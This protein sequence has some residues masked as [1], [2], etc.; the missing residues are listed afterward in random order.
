MS[1][2]RLLA[3]TH[4]TKVVTPETIARCKQN[5]KVNELLEATK[6]AAIIHSKELSM[7]Q[8]LAKIEKRE[9]KLAHK[10]GMTYDEW[11]GMS[12]RFYTI[13]AD[14][15]SVTSIARSPDTPPQVWYTNDE[16]EARVK[17]LR[18]IGYKRYDHFVKGHDFAWKKKEDA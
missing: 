14:F 6:D 15:K 2:K 11:V 3:E 8:K 17:V 5:E 12:K 1:Y 16:Y 13:G 7:E 10:S 18:L 4:A 9:R